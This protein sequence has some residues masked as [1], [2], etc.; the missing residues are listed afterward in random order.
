LHG[1]WLVLARVI[2]V[3]L[4]VFTLIIIVVASLPV[5][6]AQLQTI[7]TGAG[8]AFS[9]QLSPAQARMLKG[10]GLSP[11]AYAAYTVALTLASVVV[12]LVVSTLIIWR[13]SDDHMALLVALM[14]VTFGPILMT[15]TVVA[16]PSPWQVPN[17]CLYFLA[18]ARLPPVSHW[19]VRASLDALDHRRVSCSASPYNLLPRRAFHVEY[20]RF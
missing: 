2:W 4:A 8:C 1:S 3:V 16:S 13:R 9:Q 10:I 12:C 15:G 5:Y 18:R 20:P 6:I 19:A 11:G 17:E 7:C 14:L